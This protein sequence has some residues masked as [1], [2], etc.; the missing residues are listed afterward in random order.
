M[1]T[2]VLWLL[3]SKMPHVKQVRWCK[4]VNS[5]ACSDSSDDPGLP[6]VFLQEWTGEATIGDALVALAARL[7]RA[8]MIITTQGAKGSICLLRTQE[9][10]GQAIER[11]GG[12]TLQEWTRIA[13]T[14]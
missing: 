4:W 5:N 6:G 10:V 1:R 13:A 7:P 11:G 9:Q 2:V 3:R 12:E 8:Q 14:S